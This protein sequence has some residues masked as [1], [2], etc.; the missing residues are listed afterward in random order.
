MSVARIPVTLVTGFL[1]TGKTTFLMRL[2]TDHPNEKILFL[3]NE[4]ARQS[5]D[6]ET[7]FAT[8]RPTHSVVGGSLFCEC[9]AADFVRL[10]RE[11]IT[12]L[13]DD[14]VISHVVIET[15]GIADPS[16]IDRL[17]RDHGLNARFEIKHIVN[18]VAPQRFPQ[19]HANLPSVQAQVK[20]CDTVILNQTDL[21]SA[22]E[23]EHSSR[24]IAEANPHAQLIST[25]HCEVPFDLNGQPSQRT[26]ADAPLSTCD[27]NPFTTSTVTFER[28]ISITRLQGWLR[29]L[30]AAILRVK[31]RVRTSAGWREVQHTVAGSQITPAKAQ[32][33]S[34]LVLIVH[35]ENEPTLNR[36]V[37]QLRVLQV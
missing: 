37:H 35:D 6:G 19:L 8:G 13:H 11:D 1:G 26:P 7:L 34:Q 24:L 2:A 29:D 31:G 16:A 22:G 28:A 32:T 21:A 27:S 36:A 15:S 12:Q 9:K 14:E 17:M 10:M 18:I 23:I 20:A 30:P 4:F 25:H 3:V 5:V 33:D